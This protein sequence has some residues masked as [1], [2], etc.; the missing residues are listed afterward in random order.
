VVTV[1][2]TSIWLD[3]FRTR[4]PRRVRQEARLIIDSPDACLCEIVRFELLRAAPAKT[5]RA[6]ESYLS[7]FPTLPSPGDLWSSASALG[8]RCADKGFVSRPLD[9]LIAVVCIH[10]DAVL[11]TFD[12]G[13]AP[14]LEVCPLRLR[15]LERQSGSQGLTSTS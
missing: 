4:R 2:D 3:F 1:I 11:A 14:F 13:F 10:N 8:Q 15:L 6:L 12:K 7:T 9:L 5:R